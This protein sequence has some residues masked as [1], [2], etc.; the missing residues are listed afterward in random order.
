MSRYIHNFDIQ[1]SVYNDDPDVRKI[2]A[3][4]LVMA[5]RDRA[6]RMVAAEAEDSFEHTGT[7]DTHATQAEEA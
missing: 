6:N 7:D 1:V 3:E 4:D 5:L 2:T